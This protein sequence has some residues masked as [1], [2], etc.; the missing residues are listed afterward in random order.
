M[1][2]ESAGSFIRLI[3]DLPGRDYAAKASNGKLKLGEIGRSTDP[4]QLL[5]PSKD[6]TRSSGAGLAVDMDDTEGLTLTKRATTAARVSDSAIKET[7]L[8]P[9]A[10]GRNRP[11]AQPRPPF[12]ARLMVVPSEQDGPVK[13][14]KGVVEGDNFNSNL[15]PVLDIFPLERNFFLGNTIA[16]VGLDCVALYGWMGHR[17]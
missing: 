14:G 16:M 6:S 15:A 10:C 2:A 7:Y 5:L 13:V 11:P 3:C 4:T 17:T 8:A 12:P 1:S 9:S